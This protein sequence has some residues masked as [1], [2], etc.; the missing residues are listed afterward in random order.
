ML[1]GDENAPASFFFPGSLKGLAMLSLVIS[2]NHSVFR[3]RPQNS[4]ERCSVH[5]EAE[6]HIIVQTVA[7][8]HRLHDALP[9]ALMLLDC[10]A[11]C[12]FIVSTAT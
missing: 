10:G 2:S 12:D 4:V 3:N 9:V 1:D 8:I 6:R 7:A 11:V 5:S